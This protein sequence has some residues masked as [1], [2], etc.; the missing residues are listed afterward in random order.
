[1]GSTI[2]ALAITGDL[3][4]IAHVGDS[5]IYLIRDK[6]LRQLTTDHTKVEDLKRAGILNKEDAKNHPQKSVLNRA[7]GI[8]EHMRVDVSTHIP[9]ISGDIFVL[10][11]DGVANVTKDEILNIASNEIPPKACGK[12][13]S[14]ANERGGEDNS[15][16]QIVR[17]ETVAEV[18]TSEKKVKLSGQKAHLYSLGILA[19]V[20]I[21]TTI[22]ISNDY[23][24]TDSISRG[25]VVL[26]N[27]ID[28][29]E[30]KELFEKAQLYLKNSRYEEAV[31]T[32]Q[33]ILMINPLDNDA[34]R[35]LD[36]IA[37]HYTREGETLT[38][39]GDTDQALKYYRLA[40]EMRPE[41]TKLREIIEDLELN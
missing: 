3:A 39:R 5:R 24:K 25:N 21:L 22:Y 40:F 15:T 14:L 10:C 31:Q 26:Q 29:G 6:Q 18:K 23:R 2:S 20:F 33:Q 17:V 13:I 41:D 16:V 11:T 4:H 12:I 30:V 7:L 32:Y 35:E 28:A 36:N 27:Q 38:R 37:T 19:F 1:M 8:K 9:L 34:L